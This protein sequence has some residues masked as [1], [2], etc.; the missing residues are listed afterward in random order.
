MPQTLRTILAIVLG[1]VIGGAVNMAIVLMGP[2]LIAPPAGAD[3][4]TTEGLRASL[5]LFE[6][7]HFI[8]PLA[9][10]ALGTLVGAAVAARLAGRHATLAA[11]AVGGAFLAGGVM[12]AWMLPAP[13]WFVALDLL[14]AY[15][16]MAMV[17]RWLA[18]RT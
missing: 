10:H 12:S 14:V 2:Q 4:T 6:A 15:L 7:R 8:A 16:P 18:R 3:V 11:W 1:L 5:H 17:G 9:A 13:V